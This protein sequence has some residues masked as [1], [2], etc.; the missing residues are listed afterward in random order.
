MT[1]TETLK[2]HNPLWTKWRRYLHAHPQIAYEETI[3]SEFVQEKLTEWGVEFHTGFGI[4]GVVAVLKNGSSNRAIGLR[5]DMDAL[6]MQEENDF[7]HKSKFDGYMHACGHDGHTT[8]LLA[9]VQMLNK[10]KN[11]DGTVYAYFQPAEE[12]GSGAKA[13]IDDGMYERFPADA[14]YAIHAMPFR[15]TGTINVSEGPMLASSDQFTITV[16]GKGGHGAYPS[17]AIDPLLIASHILINLQSLTTHTRPAGQ[18]GLLHTTM[19]SGGTTHNII[20]DTAEMRGTIRSF[21]DDLRKELQDGLQRIATK[22]A[23]TFGG[24]AIINI[25][26]GDP[27][28][29]NHPE[30]TDIAKAVGLN[31]SVDKKI[32]EV[33]PEMGGEDFSHMIKGANDK[34]TM[35][36]LGIGHK[37][38]DFHHPKWEFDDEAIP[39]G[40]AFFM[41]V[42]E[43]EMPLKK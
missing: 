11:F 21:S 17:G 3:A 33:P 4:T 25:D 31:V 18:L 28:V 1:H 10:Y 26:H 15:D 43:K 38:G 9:T 40:V 27:A 5:A 6:P 8:M 7:P 22:T 37:T 35:V 12:G 23:E 16:Q 32:G 30:T 13:M 2:L 24:S 39:H 36:Y 34:G 41:G 14:V 19:L 20:P 29:I 42:I